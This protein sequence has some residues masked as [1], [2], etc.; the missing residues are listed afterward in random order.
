MPVTRAANGDEAVLTLWAR[1]GASAPDTR[2]WLTLQ[3][4]TGDGSDAVVVAAAPA[5][6][7]TG[8]AR[9]VARIDERTPPG[10][11]SVRWSTADGSVAVSPLDV[12]G[13]ADSRMPGPMKRDRGWMPAQATWTFPSGSGSVRLDGAAPS[14]TVVRAGRQLVLD[15]RWRAERSE[16][17][18]RP[19]AAGRDGGEPVAFVHLVGPTDAPGGGTVRAGQDGAASSGPWFDRPS[20]DVF[21]RRVLRVDSQAPPGQYVLEVGLYDPRSL[22]RLPVYG[23]D[24]SARR[25]VLGTVTVAR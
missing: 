23:G 15:L 10:R 12:V 24:G 11:Y 19:D 5:V 14:A 18:D 9:L 6:T 1:P 20:P 22:E 4:A 8:R 3:P 7:P 25:V 2:G 13:A 17:A 21:D 16:R